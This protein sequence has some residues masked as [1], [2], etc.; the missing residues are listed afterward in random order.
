LLISDHLEAI[1]LDP[2]IDFLLG[3]LLSRGSTMN[4][5]D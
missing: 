2:P 4:N 3:A 5:Q 1:V